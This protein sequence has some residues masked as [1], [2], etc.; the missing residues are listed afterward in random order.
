M[1]NRCSTLTRWFARTI[2][3]PEFLPPQHN[4]YNFEQNPNYTNKYQKALAQRELLLKK[5]DEKVVLKTRKKIV[6]EINYSLENYQAWRLFDVEFDL[7]EY[8]EGFKFEIDGK[9][10]A[11]PKDMVRAFGIPKLPTPVFGNS[12]GVFYFQDRNLDRFM[13]YNHDLN[14]QSVINSKTLETAFN[15]FVNSEEETEFRFVGSP[16]CEKH[17][18]KKFLTQSLEDA[19]SGKTQS[20]HEIAEAKFGKLEMWDDYEKQHKLDKQPAIYKYNRKQFEKTFKN[21]MEFI[22]DKDYDLPI[23]PVIDIRGDPDTKKL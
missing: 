8:C 23:S 22:D 21:K 15:E 10:R 3:R 20:F 6:K 16:Y 9:F 1:I 7:T 4:N 12:Y 2:K 18:F 19:I 11:K 5:L 17:R 13:V 14:A